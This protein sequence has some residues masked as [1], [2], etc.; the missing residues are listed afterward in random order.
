[1]TGWEAHNVDSDQTPKSVESDLDL[2][3]AQA[4]LS[5]YLG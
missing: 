5:E 3:C 4:L 1:M 2:H